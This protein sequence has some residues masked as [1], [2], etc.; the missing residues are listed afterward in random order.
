VNLLNT[1][2]EYKS[3][4]QEFVIKHQEIAEQKTSLTPDEAFEETVNLMRAKGML[5]AGS[6]TD[7]RSAAAA[8][9]FRPDDGEKG[10]DRNDKTSKFDLSKIM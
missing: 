2:A 6:R 9:E 7:R 8:A 10:E 3:L 1:S 5:P 4:S